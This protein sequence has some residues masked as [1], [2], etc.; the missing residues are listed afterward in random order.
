MAASVRD[1]SRY[2]DEGGIAWCAA[3]ARRPRM[4]AVCDP[5]AARDVPRRPD[6]MV[7]D[8]SAHAG[9][10]PVRTL[11]QIARGLT[12]VGA[13]FLVASAGVIV[14]AVFR[15][16]GVDDLV[17]ALTVAGLGLGLP[18]I[19]AFVVAWVLNSLGHDPD[20]VDLD[21]EP[22]PVPRARLMAI[23]LSYAFAVLACIAAR[24][25]R[26][27]LDPLLGNRVV[28]APLLLA[29]AISAWYGGLGPAVVA[30]LLGATISWT[31]YLRPNDH[32]GAID[33]PDAVQL[34]LFVAAALCIGGIAS[35]LRASREQAQA[36]AHEVL[37]RQSGL[38]AARGELAAER[39]RS[40]V[41]LQAIADA[42]IATDAQGCVTFANDCAAALTG[43]PAAEAIGRPLAR[44]LRLIDGN[45]RRPLDVALERGTPDPATDIVVVARDGSERQIEFKVSAIRDRD[46]A[47]GGFVLVF[48]DVTLAREAR[49]ALE[50]SE[51]RFRVLADQVPVLVWMAGAAGERT[52]VNRPWL[53]FTGR[54]MEEEAG[55]G[56]TTGIHPED[57]GPQQAALAEAVA[58][59]KPFD[60]EYR[61]RRHDGE[62]R[63]V[64]DTGVPR[65]D[66]SGFAGYVGAAID[67]TDR[68]QAEATLGRFEQSKS[69]FLAMLAHEL[70][71]PLAPIRSSIE[72]LARL[73]AVEDPR[74]R[75]AQE[76][77]ER[78]CARLA[79]LVDDLIDLSRIDS[80]SVHLA[81]ERVDLRQVVENAVARHEAVIRDH[82]QRLAVDVGQEPLTVVGDAGRLVQVIGN[83]I[84][85]ASKFTPK[86]G[87]V[88]VT[89][90]ARNGAAEIVVA[91][92]GQGIDAAAIPHLF[93]LFDRA[94][95]ATHGLGTGLAIVA[96]LTR[97]MGGEV[98]AR[99]DGANAGSA[100]TLRFPLADAGAVAGNGAEGSGAGAQ[101]RLL[102]VDD[103][104]DAADAMG[105][106]LGLAGFE[107]VTAHDPESALE[108]AI[109]LDPD[110]VLLDIGL[111]G[112]TGYELA[113]KLAKHPVTGRAK[114]IAV[115]GY[116]QPG[117]TEQA[118]AAGFAGYL[119]KP[120]NLA[121]LRERIASILDTLP[122]RA[123]R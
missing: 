15:T 44:V 96:R 59:R 30:T 93:D 47:A 92:D 85:N 71:N 105:T 107:V 98:E 39:D 45:T 111:P 53:E 89:A 11:A 114:V 2:N 77:I 94:P 5:A 79:E 76:I 72:L 112:M 66:G 33:I 67:I 27:A 41:T 28:Y 106:L 3:V 119:V 103:N 61:L 65:S 108:R 91:D 83:L 82:E 16:V 84:G 23:A 123:R 80:G 40:Q 116:G 58:Q 74:A 55:T 78:Q 120:V 37:A 1:G 34:G 20:S 100:F 4:P 97:L 31:V 68:K 17:I 32:F 101:H 50:E 38:E 13:A 87:C 43:W 64:L 117:D 21:A 56:W 70:R 75:R 104:V 81:R 88:R 95:D 6:S 63:F 36:L 35:A 9:L 52:Y 113:A 122:S 51:A 12:W 110:I 10:P 99:S 121:Q 49:A 62:Y 48:R 8:P 109:A 25:L 115:T 57:F 22:P 60:L 18:A 29:V 26:E 42:V 19:V 102:V 54:S 7:T 90:N 118:K 69:A 86:A 24:G 14:W 73:P 46:G